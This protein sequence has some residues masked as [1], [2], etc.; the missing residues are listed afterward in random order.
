M[1]HPRRRMAR[2]LIALALTGLLPASPATAQV[3]SG[4]VLEDGTNRP[5]DGALVS[6]VDTRGDTKVQTLADAAGRFSIA[7]KKAGEYIVQAERIGYE[8]MRSPLFAMTP[9]GA[10]EMDLVMDPQPIGLEGLEVTTE[11]EAVELLRSIGHTPEGLGARWIDREKIEKVRT[12]LRPTDV[13]KWQALP[14]VRVRVFG[15][16]VR[17]GSALLEPLC[18]ESLR[19]G[20]PGCALTVLNG[21]V[22]DPVEV[23]QLHPDVIESIAVL[24]PED[25]ATLYGTQGGNGAI[26]IWTRR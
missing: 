11:S 13:I 1:D 21:V 14:G 5:V 6:L 25:A 18:V 22:V 24:E 7:P 16:G 15:A 8:T 23:N 9:E 17:N 10:V 12:A 20:H 26:L 19:Y 4:R 3:V 2:W